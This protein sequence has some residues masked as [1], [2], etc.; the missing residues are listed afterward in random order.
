MAGKK[1]DSNK[2]PISLIPT[3]AILA[4]AEGFA[5]GAKKYGA[6]NFREGIEY[7]RLIDSLMRHTLAF[8]AGED[9]D[10]ESGLPHVSLM[11]SN[12]AM[13]QYQTVHHPELDNRYK[14]PKKD[15]TKHK[16]RFDESGFFED[17]EPADEFYKQALES[18]KENDKKLNIIWDEND[19]GISV[20][21]DD[22]DFLK[23]ASDYYLKDL[24]LKKKLTKKRKLKP[25]R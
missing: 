12:F 14:S 16:V 10:E 5:Y 3:E 2:A 8:L 17:E 18:Y 9:I 25:K 6:H 4:M 24:K 15:I 21:E 23:D 22:Q 11:G 13:L 20:S 7:T 19:H 1:E